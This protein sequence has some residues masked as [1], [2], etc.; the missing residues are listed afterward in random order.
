MMLTQPL[1][2]MHRGG[3]GDYLRRMAFGFG[4]SKPQVAL[5]TAHDLYMLV[6]YG[7]GIH[8]ANEA[9]D[10]KSNQPRELPGRA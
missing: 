5:L 2:D 4:Q 7:L 8:G 6:L 10:N 1:V 9:V 3:Y